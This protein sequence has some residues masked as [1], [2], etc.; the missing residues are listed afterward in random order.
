VIRRSKGRRE[1]VLES[2]AVKWA[3]TRGIVVAKLTECAGIPDRIFFLPKR[4]L[5]VEFKKRS[6]EPEELQNWYLDKLLKD[7]YTVGWCDEWEGFLHIMKQR[8]VE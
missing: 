7:G 6:E 2:R 5:I 3:R 8:G 4:P 1:T